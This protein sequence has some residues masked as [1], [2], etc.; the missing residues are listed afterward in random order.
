MRGLVQI[1]RHRVQMLRA[2]AAAVAKVVE[3]AFQGRSELEDDDLDVQLRQLFYDLQ[4]ARVL[5]VERH[6]YERDGR[7]LRG[8]RWH[9]LHD[10]PLTPVRPHRGPADPD[11]AV[12]E[13][14]KDDAWKRRPPGPDV[15]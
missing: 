15:A 7:L 4:D 11:A 5:D 9:L 3:E 6:E 1:L 13:D 8:Y 2:D 14:L 12:Y 10:E